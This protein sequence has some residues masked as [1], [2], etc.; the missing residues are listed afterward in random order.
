RTNGPNS[1]TSCSASLMREARSNRSGGWRIPAGDLERLVINS[2]RTFLAD[3]TAIL[4]AVSDRLHPWFTAKPTDRTRPSGCGRTRRP[5]TRQG[6]S[7]AYGTVMP[8]G[9]PPRSHRTQYLSTPSCA[10]L[11]PIDLS[12]DAGSQVRR[13]SDDIVTLR[14]PARLKRVG[15]EMRMLVENSDD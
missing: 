5:G 14:V 15:R 3:P 2:L 13:K 11:W 8:S 4:D 12:D 10:A 1:C 7:D 9:R 6:Q